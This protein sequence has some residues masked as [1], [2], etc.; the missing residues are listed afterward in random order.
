MGN[1]ASY[2]N[3]FTSRSGVFADDKHIAYLNN[4]SG[5]SQVWMRPIHH[6]EPIQLTNLENRVWTLAPVSLDGKLFFTSDMGGNEQEQIYM[7]D[8]KTKEVKNL[9]N[10][11]NARYNFGGILPG[12]K[13]II[14]SSTARN[15]AHYDICKVNLET[16]EQTLLHEN[17]DNYNIP[18]A[19]SP[20]GRYF[21]YN[22]MKGLSDN[23]LWIYDIEKDE[24]E[25]VDA[26]AA[27]AQYTHPAWKS[28]ST[29]FFL[30]TDKDAEFS[31]IAYYDVATKALTR[32]HT[33][34]WDIDALALSA[35]DRYLAFAVNVEGYME[36]KIFDLKLNAFVNTITPPKGVVFS[37]TGF[38]WSRTGHKLL[39]GSMS[40][41]RPGNV[42][43]LDLD[44]DSCRRLTETVFDGITA[45]DLVEPELRR[46]NSFDGL[47]VPYWL[48]KKSTTPDNAPVIVE[49]HGGPEGQ[50]LPLYSALLMYLVN[51]GFI[52]VAPN[53]RGSVG[54][55]KAYTHLDDIEKR[56]DSVKD[57]GSLVEHLIKSGIGQP[58]KF[59]VMG[60]S[61]GGY[62]TLASITEFPELFSAAVDTVGMSDLETFLENTAEYRR[63]HRE[64]EYGSLAKH[65]HVLRAVSP[66]H[67]VNEIVTPLMVIH[68]ENDPRVPVSEA[69]QIVKSLEDRG[70]AVKCLIYGDEGHGLAKL[71]NQLDCYPQVAEFL[72]KHLN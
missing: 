58:G 7:L 31:Y 19:L 6:G 12:G 26:N 23:Y 49:I 53:V 64:S 46:F 40:V 50:E 56:L 30:L 55:G 5:V 72:Q 8:T 47:S 25:N 2:F 48:Y 45:D 52:I 41:K 70:V 42:W 14:V 36:L 1:I 35:D 4:S 43:L 54:Y 71:K 39:F 37:Y 44:T 13:E 11:P 63:A 10:N 67:K 27:F 20:N 21:L 3:I 32:I 51:E 18:A 69:R 57:I 28:D 59:S 68:G 61:Y 17:N 29:G 16:L 22:K 33:E 65:R 38:N 60:G 15:A 9:T 62:M 66:I 24:A 34:N